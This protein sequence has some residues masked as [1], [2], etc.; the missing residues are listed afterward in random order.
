MPP[1]P[2][3]Q[4]VEPAVSGRQAGYLIA[5][6]SVA[7]AGQNLLLAIHAS[8]LGACWVCAPLFCPDVVGQELDLPE[9][10]Q[11]QGLITL[12]YP[13]D[14]GKP[15]A[16]HPLDSVRRP[17]RRTPEE[18]PLHSMKPENFYR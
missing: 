9:D 6:Q 4:F 1:D 8:G 5:V 16:R 14:A 18:A 2:S 15:P 12:G 13:A 11:P 17:S 3:R 7:M 10:W